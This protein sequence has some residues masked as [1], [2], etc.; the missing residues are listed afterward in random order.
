MSDDPTNA[1]PMERLSEE[2]WESRAPEVR[3]RRC[4]AHRR[5]GA[6]CAKVAM[7]AQR[8][9]GTHGGRAPQAKS[10]ARQRIEEAADRLALRALS[11][12]QSDKVP[13]YVALQATQDLLDRAGV[14]AKTAVEVEV[15]VKPYE[16]LLGLTGIAQITR[17][18]SR[19]LRGL[20][21]LDAP[22]PAAPIDAEVVEAPE[23]APD[24]PARGRTPADRSDDLPMRPAFATDYDGPRPGNALMTQEQAMA[25]I[26][27]ARLRR[28]Y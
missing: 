28:R 27:E 19:E 24:S 23:T 15:E 9:C 14:S 5:N 3:A 1:A 12:A 4:Q 13:A 16:E 18:E 26:R 10:K 21:A 8:V 17:A 20:P 25:E 11:I 7:Q 2:W 22:D 6:Q